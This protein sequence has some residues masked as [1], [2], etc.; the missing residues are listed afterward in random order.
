M[1]L[2]HLSP[3]IYLIRL[4]VNGQVYSQSIVIYR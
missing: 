3:G 4:E 1:D 2:N